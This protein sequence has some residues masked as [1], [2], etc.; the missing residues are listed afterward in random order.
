MFRCP[1]CKQTQLFIIAVSV[2][3]E[4]EFDDAGE[5]VQSEDV[6]D[7]EWDGNSPIECSAGDCGHFGQIKDFRRED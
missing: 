5:I 2:R 6:S 7:T 4:Y 3:R 1:E